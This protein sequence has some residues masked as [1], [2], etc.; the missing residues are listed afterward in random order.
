MDDIPSNVRLDGNFEVASGCG[1][2]RLR[3]PDVCTPGHGDHLEPTVQQ[4]I[5]IL[6]ALSMSPL[7]AISKSPGNTN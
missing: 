2:Q 7:T 6:G 3:V 4:I 1:S 5:T